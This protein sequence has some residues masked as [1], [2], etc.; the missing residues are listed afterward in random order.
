MLRLKNITKSYVTGDSSVEA[1][2]GVDIEF[3]KCEF[4]SILGP[5]GCGKTTLLNIIGGLDQYTNGDMAINSVSTKNYTDRDWDDYRN[6]SVGFVFQSY[7]LIPHQTV[8]SNVELALTIAGISKEERKKRAIAALEKVGLGDQLKK[9]PSQM[10]GGQMQ[11]VAIAR[12]IVNDPEILLADE[13]TGALDTETSVQVMDILKEISKDRLVIMVTHNPEL[14]EEY[15]TRIIRLLDGKIIS[16]T[17]PY[18]VAEYSTDKK[19][20]EEKY[21]EKEKKKKQ[22]KNS[23]SHKTAISLSFNNLL[24]KKGRT[25]MTSFAGSIGIIGIALILALSSGIQ[26][27]IDKV[28]RET[29]STYPLQIQSETVDYSGLIKGMQAS[30]ESDMSIEKD[31]NAIY[32]SDVMGSFLKTLMS[33]VRKNNLS[34]FKSYIE[35]NTDNIDDLI[36]A[37]DYDY[38]VK[39]NIYSMKNDKTVQVNPSPVMDLV[40]EKMMGEGSSMPSMEMMGQDMSEMY[41]FD[42]WQQMLSGKDGELIHPIISEQYELVGESSRWPTEYNEVVLVVDKS[43]RLND[44]ALYTLNIKDQEIM[45]ERFDAIFGNKELETDEITKYTFDELL[46]E[47][48]YLATTDILFEYD[49]KGKKWIDH[50]ADKD[51]GAYLSKLLSDSDKENDPIEIKITGIIRPKPDAV[52][53]SLTAAVAYT[54]ALTERFIERVNNSKALK[55]QMGESK[56]IDIFT[57]VPFNKTEIDITLEELKA[58]IKESMSEEEA[59]KLL[60]QIDMALSMG[61]MSEEDIIE[62]YKKSMVTDATYDGNLKKLGYVDLDAP[63][64]IN[65]YTKSFEEKDL[66]T[67]TIDNYNKRMKSENK[68][69]LAIEYTDLV[70]LLMSSISTIINIISYVLIG[71]VSISLVVSSI[72]IGIITYISVLER[73]K[74]IG[75]LRA[76]GASKKDISRV[77]K[78]E[79]GIVGLFSGLV[80]IGVT[81][82]LTIPINII[83]DALTKDTSTRVSHIAS[84]PVDGAIILIIISVV[85]TLIG[86]LIPSK[87]AAKKDPVEALRSE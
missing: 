6:H 9:K 4:V 33:E 75:I 54:G 28:Q 68:E 48:F 57:G 61:F 50:S 26:G 7:N 14:A 17:S 3:R 12:A 24:T 8:L 25:F 32:S 21:K 80:G 62:E 84:L 1:L 47:K 83:V 74:E 30:A 65:I 42:M 16:D 69:D 23:M 10:S 79:T 81:V 70:G 72:M 66:L 27:F 20:K 86:G 52:A 19:G 55:S 15:S 40:F 82:L 35:N 38:K 77:F 64:M 58:Y 63:S 76:M 11:R 45:K 31:P 13:P 46:N 56:D 18:S 87:L 22:K 71:F 39:L 85:L 36:S 51:I 67:E 43:N 37:I 34:N 5:S 78:A 41:N 60:S 59:S 2:K 29:L 53:T 73:T 44:L 49:E